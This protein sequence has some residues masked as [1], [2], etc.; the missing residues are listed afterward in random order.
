MTK[1]YISREFLLSH[2]M[3]LFY[4][5]VIK[6]LIHLFTNLSGAYG[7]FRDEFYYIACS[8]H[9][10][11]GY[12]DQPPLSIALLTLSR[13]FF[14]DSLWA[15]RLLPAV[16]GAVAVFLTGKIARELGGGL[17]ARC[18]LR[19]PSLWRLSTWEPTTCIP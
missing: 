9:L 16:A 15:I 10:D 19:W 4:L 11:W 14:G 18:C 6:F 3:I 8:E 5:A 1:K 17:F 7:F 13:M 2:G 12:V